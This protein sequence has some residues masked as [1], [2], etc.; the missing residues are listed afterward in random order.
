MDGNRSHLS[1]L[2]PP[3]L[4]KVQFYLSTKMM[5]LANVYDLFA[6]IEECNV[7]EICFS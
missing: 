1:L 4:Y 3:A 5:E 2:Y 6:D 7:E